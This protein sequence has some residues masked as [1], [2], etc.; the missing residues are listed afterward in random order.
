MIT[1]LPTKK[2]KILY[3]IT[4]SNF[5]G[6]QKYVYDLARSLPRDQFE[7]MVALGG[8]GVLAEKLADAHVPTV[9]IPSLQR[10]VNPFKDFATLIALWKLFRKE[11]PDVIHLN[12]AKA[13][14]LGALAGRLVLVKKI[15]F[16]A[17]GWAFNEDRSPLSRFLITILSWVTVLLAHKTIAVSNAVKNDTI[18]WPFVKDKITTIRNGISSPQFTTCDDSRC[19]IES[20][21]NISFPKDAFIIGTVAELH[22]NKGLTY[23]LNA[24]AQLAPKNPHIF[25]VIFGEGEERATLQTFIKEHGL[26][27]RVFLLGFVKNAVQYMPGLDCFILP[28]IKEGLPYVLLEAGLAYRP[29]IATAVGGIPEIIEDTQTGLLVPPKNTTALAGAISW[30]LSNPAERAVLGKKLNE[31]ITNFFTLEQ[32]VDKTVALYHKK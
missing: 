21:I 29:V 10:D 4:K 3:V 11:R 31:K 8:E 17:H 28:S 12:S 20:V 30:I 16:T 14:G 32:M 5:G 6:A 22:K 19:D 26:E 23:T 18:K 7:I 13:S 1:P 2:T 25:Y 24:F 9:Y 27:Q 15:V